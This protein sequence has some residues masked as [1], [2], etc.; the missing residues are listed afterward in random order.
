MCGNMELCVAQEIPVDLTQ[1]HK[2]FLVV[3]NSISEIHVCS[4]DLSLSTRRFSGFVA[5]FFW[6]VFPTFL[7]LL[8]YKDALGM[9][10]SGNENIV[11]KAKKKKHQHDFLEGKSLYRFY[12]NS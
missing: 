12:C 8:L 2:W 3:I 9:Y 7:F 1:L 4:L 6:F 5:F 11:V 10:F